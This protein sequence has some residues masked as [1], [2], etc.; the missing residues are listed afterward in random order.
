MQELE[1]V[2][3]TV[4]CVENHSEEPQTGLFSV[5]EIEEVVETIKKAADEHSG[6]HGS[7]ASMLPCLLRRLQRR[8]ASRSLVLNSTS[9]QAG[10]MS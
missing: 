7:A 4:V 3:E 5:Q 10:T 8:P 1:E 6:D 2:V 9:A